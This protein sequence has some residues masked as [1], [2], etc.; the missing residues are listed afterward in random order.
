MNVKAAVRKALEYV[1]EV[2]EAENI[3]NLGLEEVEFDEAN[4]VWKI[5]V[6]FSRPWDYAAKSVMSAMAN[7]LGQPKRSYKVLSIRDDDADVISIK[8]HEVAA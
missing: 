3:S 5:T 1:G 8:S 4:K 2:F 6:G 7:P